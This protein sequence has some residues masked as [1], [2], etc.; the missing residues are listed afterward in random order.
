[1]WWQNF[2]SRLLQLVSGCFEPVLTVVLLLA[3]KAEKLRALP[4]AM[5]GSNI[6]ARHK[7]PATRCAGVSPDSALLWHH[8]GSCT[9]W[10][11]SGIIIRLPVISFTPV[12]TWRL[13][14]Q[15]LCSFRSKA[16]TSAISH[17]LSSSGSKNWK[18]SSDLKLLVWQP[19]RR[20]HQPQ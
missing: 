13:P 4:S 20:C 6:R 1:M 9:K 18:L 11:I 7:L 10:S 12:I 2:F 15:I 3:L 16:H 8:P 19:A 17:P 14:N 5:E